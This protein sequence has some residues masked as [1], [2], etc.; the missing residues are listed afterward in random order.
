M[1]KTAF[2][3]HKLAEIKI[4]VF[5]DNTPALLLYSGFGFSPC[6]IE[7][8]RYPSGRRV[9]LIH[10]KKGRIGVKTCKTGTRPD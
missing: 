10:M 5:S 2:E 9:A 7:E 3:K 4:S 1:L 6:E 8:R